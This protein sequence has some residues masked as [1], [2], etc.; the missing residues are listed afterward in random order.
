MSGEEST[1][2]PSLMSPTTLPPSTIASSFAGKEWGAP[3]G[4]TPAPSKNTRFFIE[5]VT[6][7]VSISV[8]GCVYSNS[9]LLIFII[10]GGERVVQSSASLFREELEHIQ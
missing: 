4:S 8:L 1:N 9:G 6:F 5:N 10:I 7:L 3:Q 2:T